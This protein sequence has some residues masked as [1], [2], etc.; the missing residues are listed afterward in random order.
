[1]VQDARKDRSLTNFHTFAQRERQHAVKVQT[2]HTSSH[3]A[4]RYEL[5]S[6]SSLILCLITVAVPTSL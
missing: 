5:T 2:D 1:M 4:G 6:R 3:Y